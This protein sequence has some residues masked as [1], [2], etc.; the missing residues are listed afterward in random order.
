MFD[1]RSDLIGLFTNDRIGA[2]SKYST[3][4]VYIQLVSW[5]DNE[6]KEP[7]DYGSKYVGI[8]WLKPPRAYNEPMDIGFSTT[9]HEVVVDCDLLIP[10][11]DNWLR[12]T[13]A[14]YIKNICHTFETTIRR[15]ASA[16]GKTWDTAELRSIPISFD[17]ENPGVYRRVFEVIFKKHD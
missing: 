5:E 6:E 16:S 1:P 9:M 4:S 14:T 2:A 17:S 15:N 8:L 12:N 10:K 7:D 3:T 13:H 11:N